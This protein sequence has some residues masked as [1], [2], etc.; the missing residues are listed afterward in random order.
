[1]VAAKPK[2]PSEIG[3]TKIQPV[4]LSIASA[5]HVRVFNLPSLILPAKDASLIARG[6]LDLAGRLSPSERNPCLVEIMEIGHA[7][8]KVLWRR[9]VGPVE[10]PIILRIAIEAL[11][12][13]KM[14]GEAD[15]ALGRDTRGG[16]AHCREGLGTSCQSRC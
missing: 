1:M 15:A 9:R 12:F 14:R 13:T 4:R 10:P 8:G 3:K 11:D 2:S 16:R 5:H 7:A 6:L